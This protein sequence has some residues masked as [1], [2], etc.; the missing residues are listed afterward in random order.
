MKKKTAGIITIGLFAIGMSANIQVNSDSSKMTLKN[1]EGISAC[2][3][4]PNNVNGHCVTNI[5]GG[6]FCA[7]PEGQ[8]LDCV[9]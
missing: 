4:D 2:E 3:N 9:Q 8:S 5:H 6:T 7:R 1:I